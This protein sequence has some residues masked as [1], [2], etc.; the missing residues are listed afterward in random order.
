MALRNTEASW[1]AVTKWLHWTI[2]ALMI[3][4]MV[5]S[6]WADQLDPDIESHRA[7]WQILI[8]RLHKPLGF[9]ALVLIAL[10]LAWTLSGNRPRLPDSMSANEVRLSRFVHVVLYALMLVVPVTGWF[11]SQYADSTVN[12]GLFEIPNIVEPDKEKIKPLHTVHVNVGLFLLAL[13]LLHVAAAVFHEFWRKDDVLKSM[14]PGRKP[15][16]GR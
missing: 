7:L 1:G 3:A 16:A 9:T 10:R 4:A 6:I 15:S 5:C 2:A 14:L 8:M 12:F 11:M 13:V